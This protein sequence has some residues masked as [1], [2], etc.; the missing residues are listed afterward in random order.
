MR[1][2][3]EDSAQYKWLKQELA[4]IDRTV[5]PW[6]TVNFHNPW[7]AFRNAVMLV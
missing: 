2:Y 7:E 1:D 4:E 5:T 3:M 6:V